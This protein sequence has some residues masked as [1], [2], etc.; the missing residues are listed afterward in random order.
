MS[1][2]FILLSVVL[3][4]PELS[5]APV[6]QAIAEHPLQF[7]VLAVVFAVLGGGAVQH[8]QWIEGK[9]T[10]AIA[11]SEL[12]FSAIAG[13]IAF[14][15]AARHERDQLDLCVAALLLG[16]AGRP[17]LMAVQAIASKAFLR[18]VANALGVPGETGHAD[19]DQRL[20]S[21]R[22]TGGPDPNGD[23][24]HPPEHPQQRDADAADQG[25]PKGPP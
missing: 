9:T 22:G 25:Q 11:T 17:V 13:V 8:R 12:F 20:D 23:R 21:R 1:K 2:W 5:P 3:S 6:S 16:M 4:E 14:W 24:Q 15:L 10:L 19:Q 18:A 7:G